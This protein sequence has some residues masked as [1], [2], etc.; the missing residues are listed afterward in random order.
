MNPR[1]R[2]PLRVLAPLSLV[3]FFIAFIIVLASSGVSD[4]GPSQ[5]TQSGSPAATTT[6]AGGQPAASRRSSYTVKAGD[7][8]G[9]IA[10]KTG[11]TVAKLEELNPDLEP[12]ALVAGQKIKLRE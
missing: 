6:Q 4:E 7:T 10:E 2:S 8:L 11:L 9:A 5:A 1:S 12:Q 3:A